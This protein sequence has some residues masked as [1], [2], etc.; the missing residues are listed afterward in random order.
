MKFYI[1]SEDDSNYKAI[2]D[3]NTTA[4][5]AWNSSGNNA[6]GMNELA[7]AL[8]NDT[9]SWD[10]SLNASIITADEVAAI[11]GNT[12]FDSTTS[13]GGSWFYFD[14]NSQTQTATS[15]GASKYAWLYDY[16]WDCANYGCNISENTNYGYWTSTP[17]FGS[18]SRAW[19]V[20]RSGNLGCLAVSDMSGHGLRPVIT[21]SKSI[22]S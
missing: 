18:S 15:Q 3:H 17:V 5:V 22:V 4:R 10:S 11:T 6:D 1:Y 8:T 14:S 2:L 20:K 12:S 9:S 16:S 7:S 21:I 19:Y 13:T